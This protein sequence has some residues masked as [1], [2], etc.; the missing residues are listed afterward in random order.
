MFGLTKLDL[1][2]G[3][4]NRMGDVLGADLGVALV[5][6]RLSGQELRGAVLRCCGCGSESA[7][8]RWL[9]DHRAGAEA[10]PAYCRNEALF[11]RLKP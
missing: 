8:D 6:G 5:E 11:E 9:E 1:H 3:L 10:A 7:C 4:V 2:A